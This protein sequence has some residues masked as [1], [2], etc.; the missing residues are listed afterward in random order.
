MI[1]GEWRLDKI[2]LCMLLS[3]DWYSACREL[4]DY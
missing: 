1:E 3:L 2:L 4:G